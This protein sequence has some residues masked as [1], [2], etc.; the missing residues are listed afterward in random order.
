VRIDP[1]RLIRLGELI[2]QGSFRRAADKLSITQPALSQS[3]AQMEEE[4]GVRLIDRTPHG[5]LPT[6]YGQA[7]L[8]HAVAIERQLFDAAQKITELS[9]GHRWVLAIGGTSGAA[10]SILALAVCRLR[11]IMPEIETRIIEETWSPALLAQLDDHSLDIVICY[12]PDDVELEG[13]LALPAFQAR[14]LLCVR[15]DHPVADNLT[16]ANL[17]NYPFVCPIREM[18]IHVEI[19]RIFNELKIDF[20]TPQVFVSNSLSATKEIVLN[21]DAFA[22]LSDLSVLHESKSGSIRHAEIDELSTTFW[23][24]MVVRE[25]YVVTELFGDFISAFGKVCRELGIELH[26]GIE[27]IRKGR[28]LLR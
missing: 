3:I 16:L 13:K 4:V 25:E 17:A 27:R 7:L 10:I 14:R 18:G 26:P 5:V 1:Q 28:R 9:F 20:P 2:K 23:F 8:N 22:I 11:E 21:S 19:K 15:A 12:K 24:Y 6:L